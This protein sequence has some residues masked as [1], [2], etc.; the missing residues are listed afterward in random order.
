M[1]ILTSLMRGDTVEFTWQ[2]DQG[3]FAVD[4]SIPILSTEVF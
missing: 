1:L 4:L 3:Y 2:D